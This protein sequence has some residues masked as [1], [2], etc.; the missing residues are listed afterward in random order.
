M[1]LCFFGLIVTGESPVSF[2]YNFIVFLNKRRFLTSEKES[3]LN[4]HWLPINMEGRK[5][6]SLSHDKNALAPEITEGF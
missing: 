5:S 3:T 1:E 6:P 4:Y 2:N